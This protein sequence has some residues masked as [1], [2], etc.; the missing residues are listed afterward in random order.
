MRGINGNGRTSGFVSND[1]TLNS[2]FETGRYVRDVVTSWTTAHFFRFVACL[3]R[4]LQF[5]GC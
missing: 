5:G 3:I 1:L 4:Y 2:A